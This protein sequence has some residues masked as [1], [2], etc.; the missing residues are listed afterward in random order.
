MS[1]RSL[2]E[3]NHDLGPRY[4]WPDDKLIRYASL[5]ALYLG[6]GD[7]ADL[8]DG[9]TFVQ[10][11]HHSDP[12]PTGWVPLRQD[13]YRCLA[14][15]RGEWRSVWWQG[16]RALWRSEGLSLTMDKRHQPKLFAPLPDEPTA[17]P[18]APLSG[19]GMEVQRG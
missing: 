17:A 18:P 11:R 12:A 6:S 3:F 2:L 15:M 5:I 19:S 1:N 8:P 9:V 14:F 4:G 16:R 7:K 10:M 13:G